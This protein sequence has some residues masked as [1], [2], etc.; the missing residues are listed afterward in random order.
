MHESGTPKGAVQRF[1]DLGRRALAWIFG[2]KKR[3]NPNIYPLY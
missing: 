3:K 1:F 2:R